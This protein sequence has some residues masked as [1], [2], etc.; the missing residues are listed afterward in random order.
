MLEVRNLSVAYGDSRVLDAVSLDAADGEL[1][2][3]LGPSGAGKSTLLR[4]IAGLLVP[5]TGVI[6][7]EGVDLAKV[8]PHERSF[9]LMFQD[10]ALFPHRTVGQNVAFGL[11]M[12]GDEGPDIDRRVDEVLGWVNLAG[13]EKR[14]ISTLSGGEQQRVAL[15]RALAPE[16]KLLML[17]EPVG[18]LDRSL[19][20]RLVDELRSVLGEQRITSLYVTH[21]QD[22]AMILADRVVIM[23]GGEVVQSGTPRQLWEAP[24]SRWIAEFLDVGIPV[25][26][27]PGVTDRPSVIRREAVTLGGPIS[28][29]VTNV[30]FRSG[31][32]VVQVITQDGVRLTVTTAHDPPGHGDHV[33]LTIDPTGVLPLD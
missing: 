3:I 19:R 9:G 23:R 29:E 2:A 10:Y 21:D 12:R 31:N 24:A 18:S 6:S 30:S 16:P 8:P 27:L 5:E 28:A 11:R 33:G 15:A 20:Q 1:V 7:W 22:E 26:S 32:Y 25:E 17:D 14:A 4:A 13:F